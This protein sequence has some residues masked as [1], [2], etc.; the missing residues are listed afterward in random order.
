MVWPQATLQRFHWTVFKSCPLVLSFVYV[1]ETKVTNFEKLLKNKMPRRNKS[2]KAKE[3][4]LKNDWKKMDSAVPLEDGIDDEKKEKKQL[5]ECTSDND[6]CSDIT[7][8]EESKEGCSEEDDEELLEAEN[9]LLKLRIQ[10]EQKSRRNDRLKEIKEETKLLE[11]S[12]LKGKKKP[13]SRL[14]STKN[15]ATSASL[16]GMSDVVEKVNR[17]MDEKKLNFKDE[18]SSGEEFSTSSPSQSSRSESDDSS[19]DKEKKRRRK[20]EKKRRDEKRKSGKEKKLTSYVRFPQKWPHSHLK[21]HFVSKEKK[22]DDLSL[23]EFCAGYMS[24]L[25]I[26]KKSHREARITHLEELMYHATTKPWKSVLNYHAACLMEIERGSLK[27]GDNFQIHGIQNTTLFSS[28]NRDRG[29]SIAGVDNAKNQLGKEENGKRV[30]FCS[31]YNRGTC[32]YTREHYGVVKGE[33]QL[34]KHICAKCFLTLKKQST[35]SEQS[36]DCPLSKVEL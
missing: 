1:F 24:I 10:E 9:K 14:A 29:N 4:A 3:E 31:N 8:E 34:V 17:L 20:K 25:S 6:M 7:P 32:T 22:Y 35:H 19:S 26:C 33:N 13:Q 23:A 2:R 16:R 28:V 21:L 11:E 12:L 27:W 15:K 5:E 36:E 18:S 30:W